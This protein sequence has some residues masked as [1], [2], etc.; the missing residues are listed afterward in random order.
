MKYFFSFFVSV[1]D[2]LYSLNVRALGCNVRLPLNKDECRAKSTLPLVFD[3]GRSN[4]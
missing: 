1:I 4:V 3:F 2:A